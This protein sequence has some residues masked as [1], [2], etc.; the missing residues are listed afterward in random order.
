MRKIASIIAVSAVLSAT[1]TSVKSAGHVKA[2]A[3]EHAVD[4]HKAAR[5]TFAKEHGAVD[6]AGLVKAAGDGPMADLLIS[7]AIEESNG[8]VNAVGKAGEEGAWQVIAREWGA[9]PEHLHGQAKQA[10]RIVK[11]LVHSTGGNIVKAL[12][13]YNGGTV[14]GKSSWKYAGRVAERR[15]LFAKSFVQYPLPSTFFIDNEQQKMYVRT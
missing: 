12:A 14:P 15:N 13:R 1:A 2:P 4:L 3:G 8:D 7:I 10:E 6:P 9:V 11:E 5:I